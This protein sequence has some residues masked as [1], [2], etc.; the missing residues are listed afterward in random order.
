MGVCGVFHRVIEN[1]TV[2]STLKGGNSIKFEVAIWDDIGRTFPL[3]L[4]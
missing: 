1:E 3:R 4:M 2:K